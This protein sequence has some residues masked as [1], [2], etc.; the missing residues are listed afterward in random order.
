[1]DNPSLL[2]DVGDDL[3][4][5]RR[6][7]HGYRWGWECLYKGPRARTSRGEIVHRET[8]MGN[9]LEGALGA[10]DPETVGEVML[11]VMS[12]V[13]SGAEWVVVVC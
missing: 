3:E 12:M 9:Q 7:W 11:K 6:I 5:L 10:V 13:L 4:N 2:V 8:T 1:V